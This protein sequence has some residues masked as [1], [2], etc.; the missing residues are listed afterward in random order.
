MA[1]GGGPSGA[2]GIELPDPVPLLN[3]R[4]AYRLGGGLAS[5]GGPGD[6]T[7]HNASGP[8]YTGSSLLSREELWV[9]VDGERC[10]LRCEMFRCRL[11]GV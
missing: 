2:P 11:T 3:R 6:G 5:A 10:P 4:E 1:M 8:W 9:E 7:W